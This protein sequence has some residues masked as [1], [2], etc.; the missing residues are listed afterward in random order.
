MFWSLLLK[1]ILMLVLTLMNDLNLV[2]PTSFGGK[3]LLF[4]C[5]TALIWI[6]FSFRAD[7]CRSTV[8]YIY[9]YRFSFT[10]IHESQHS[11]GRGRAFF[12]LLTT[13]STHPLHR[14]LDISWAITAESSPL[15][16]ASSQTRTRNLRFPSAGC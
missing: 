6:G 13:T 10:N 3:Q 2:S 5:R 1:A 8:I 11:R 15:H 9:I 4:S 14:H 16:I 7:K 12:Y